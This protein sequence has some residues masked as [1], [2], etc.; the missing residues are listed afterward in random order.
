MTAFRTLAV[1]GCCATFAG[2]AWGS[3]WTLQSHGNLTLETRHFFHAAPAPQ[4]ARWQNSVALAPEFKAFSPSGAVVL[5]GKG[6]YRHDDLDDER[7]H[8][9]LR[10]AKLEWR[11]G[12]ND[13]TLGVDNVFWGKTES[14][15]LVDVINQYDDV[16]GVFTD[17]KLGQPM[18]RL[19]RVA[20]AGV[21]EAYYLPYSREATFSGRDGRLRTEP[22]IKGDRSIYRNDHDAWYPGAA[23]RWEPALDAFE[24]G[25]S[26]FH[27]VSRDPSY[28]LRGTAQ[29]P[30]FSPVYDV[31]TQV[32]VDA[33]YAG[34]QT[35]YKLEAIYRWD[36]LDLRLR[37]RNY[38]A[39]T[40]GLEHTLGGFLGTPGDLG[41]IVEY[42]RDGLGEDSIN[43]LQ[44][45][46][47][48]G[49]RYTLNDIA[50]TYLL[51]TVAHDRH[52]GSELYKLEFTRRLGESLRLRIEAFV[53]SLHDD[54]EFIYGYRRDASLTAAL[55]YYW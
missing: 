31:V 28:Q 2:G 26:A 9:D 30:W 35:L 11:Q 55:G 5:T 50:D 49:V 33:L 53:P 52:Y 16:E 6:F 7:T 44:D 37:P 20:D 27:G 22:R 38:A 32:G 14:Q 46:L 18:A 19:R 17:E 51:A 47:V 1:A 12:D 54:A 8:W 39:A 41:L 45:D 25:L 10:E 13:L 3:G 29:D 48:L 4:D 42:N 40:L 23:L 21:F 24:L 34:E 36:Q 15:N 43:A